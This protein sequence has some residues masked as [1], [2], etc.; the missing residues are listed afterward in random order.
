MANER[1][2]EF[3]FHNHAKE[4]EKRDGEVIM[5]YLI[6]NTDPANVFYELDVYWALK[7]GVDPTEYINKFAGRFPVLHIKDESI[8]GETGELDFRAIFDAAYAQ[9]M[10]DYYVEVEKYTLPPLNCVEKSYDFLYGADFV[11]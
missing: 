1:G 5:D 10:K 2:L 8:I 4:F 6:N 3:G 11:K 9:G 7:G